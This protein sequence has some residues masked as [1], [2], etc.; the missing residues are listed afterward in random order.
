MSGLTDSYNHA[1]SQILLMSPLPTINQAYA[2]LIKEEQHQSGEA[3]SM[4]QTQCLNQATF[5]I[6]RQ[7]YSTGNPTRKKRDSNLTCDYCHKVGHRKA[8]CYHLTDFPPNF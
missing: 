5:T 2:M 8:Q 3:F 6:N 4:N 1:K 7:N